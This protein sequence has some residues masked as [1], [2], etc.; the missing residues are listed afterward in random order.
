M[1]GAVVAPDRAAPD[2]SLRVDG[3]RNR[4]KP[5]GTHVAPVPRPEKEGGMKPPGSGFVA[6]ALGLALA[7]VAATPMRAA[8]EGKSVANGKS[9]DNGKPASHGNK[10]KRGGGGSACAGVLDTSRT[11]Q[12]DAPIAI[13]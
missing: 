13:D 6:L 3:P 12:P 11:G 2:T 8:G 10:G 5:A 1:P 4:A 7:M 9:T